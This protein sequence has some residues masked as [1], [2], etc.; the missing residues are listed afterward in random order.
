MKKRLASILMLAVILQLC[1]ACGQTS[2]SVDTAANPESQDTAVPSSVDTD[3]LSSVPE[4]TTAPAPQITAIDGKGAEFRILGR[5]SGSDQTYE[6]YSEVD[7]DEMNAE[8]M[9][10]A[11]F[12]RNSFL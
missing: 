8:I 1:A 4:E 11:V 3:E 7:A 9:N 6:P 5:L 10:D 12:E 2:P